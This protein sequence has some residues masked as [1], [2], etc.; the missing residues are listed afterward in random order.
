MRERGNITVMENAWH[1]RVFRWW[2]GKVDHTS[3]RQLNLCSYMRCVLIYA[4]TVALALGITILVMFL[5]S[6]LR[7][8]GRTKLSNRIGQFCVRRGERITIT[9]IGLSVLTFS[10]ILLFQAF[11][12]N[13]TLTL[14]IGGS[15]IGG[16]VLVFGLIYILAGWVDS[17]PEKPKKIRPIP[18][19]NK[20]P[21]K[22]K[23]VKGTPWYSLLWAFIV[24][25]KHRVCPLITIK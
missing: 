16:L 21:V 10:C 22:V 7:W 9:A 14:I 5:I 13:W 6:P 1:H 3:G 17:R 2:A 23:K 4:P 15:V 19:L 20:K 25:K 11:S 8:F 24:A 12:A 18:K